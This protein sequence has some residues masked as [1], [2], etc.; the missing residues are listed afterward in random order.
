MFFFFFDIISQFNQHVNSRLSLL[1]MFVIWL[2]SCFYSCLPCIWCC[3][4]DKIPTTTQLRIVRSNFWTY[5]QNFS[6]FKIWF[7]F[8]SFSYIFLVQLCDNDN[9]LMATSFLVSTMCVQC[10]L[11]SQQ[12]SKL[13]LTLI[14]VFLM[15]VL[16][17]RAR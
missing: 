5:H 6:L 17:W 3:D 11:A 13:L 4:L 15:C 8:F 14:R 1:L 2:L 12:A 9:T 16:C 10:Y 7:N